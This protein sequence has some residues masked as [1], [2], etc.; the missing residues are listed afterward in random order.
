MRQQLAW[1]LGGPLI[2]AAL[3]SGCALRPVLTDVP[4]AERVRAEACHRRA[5][6]RAEVMV[7]YVDLSSPR[8]RKWSWTEIALAPVVIA[9]EV[10]QAAQ[11]AAVLLATSPVWVPI[12]ISQVQ[13]RREDAYRQAY[14]TCMREDTPEAA[15]PSR[16]DEE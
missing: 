4:L 16:G 10:A 11:G 1:F 12:W 3:L 14:A 15:D 2:G 5:I 8:L 9:G 7:P 6:E 13:D